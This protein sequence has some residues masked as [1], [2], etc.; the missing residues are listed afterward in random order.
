MA[1]LGEEMYIMECN[2]VETTQTI[3]GEND[4]KYQ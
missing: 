3:R 1:M 2:D 4:L